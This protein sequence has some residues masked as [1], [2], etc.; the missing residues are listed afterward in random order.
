MPPPKRAKKKKPPASRC[1]NRNAAKDA[2]LQKAAEAE[3]KA[4]DEA[5]KKAADKV[6]K[7]AADEA[8]KKAAD[9]AKKK[10]AD[11]AKKK[12][13]NEATKKAA[14]E[15]EKKAADEAEKKAADEM[16]EQE[17]ERKEEG[18]SSGCV[19]RA[20]FAQ[21]S[22]VVVVVAESA[23]AL[24]L[25]HQMELYCRDI[26]VQ[27]KCVSVTEVLQG[28]YTPS[29]ELT[30]ILE[31][32]TDVHGLLNDWDSR[33]AVVE[34]FYS[35]FGPNCMV[36][37]KVAMDVNLKRY[38]KQLSAFMLPG[39]VLV[40]DCSEF[41]ALADETVYYI[42]P[43]TYSNG[44]GHIPSVTGSALK[45]GLT[46]ANELLRRCGYLVS[47]HTARIVVRV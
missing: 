33:L 12:A 18:E 11:E 19:T 20:S 10:A 29:T 38:V 42:K 27:L 13:A 17:E 46:S 4:A 7:K 43:G 16:E 6:E 23:V 35:A 39:T 15:A 30:I 45:E 24:Q 22:T 32:P 47:T 44:N 26:N 9:D 3:K 1:V 2:R 37:P 41:G 14:A 21:N 28:Q 36:C 40:E 8:T 31:D 5:T 25:V 34:N